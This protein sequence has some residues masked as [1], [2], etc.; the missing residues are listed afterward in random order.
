MRRD[1]APTRALRERSRETLLAGLRATVSGRDPADDR[2]FMLAL[3]PF[4]DCARRLGVDVAE[5][6]DDAAE[7]AS[8]RVREIVTTFGRRTD[9]T[10]R[11]WAYELDEEP[12][13]PFYRY[14]MPPQPTPDDIEATL[15]SLDIE[16]PPGWRDRMSDG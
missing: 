3:A 6:F 9:I 15:R 4:H 11:A 2:D 13:G 10:P 12:D 7:S 5:L 14:E 8:Q 1:D 16:P